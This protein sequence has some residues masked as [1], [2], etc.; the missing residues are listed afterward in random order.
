MAALLA[1]PG[2]SVVIDRNSSSKKKRG[3]LNTASPSA[4]SLFSLSSS[5][6]SPSPSSRRQQRNDDSFTAAAAGVDPVESMISLMSSSSRAGPLSLPPH[7]NE[8]DNDTRSLSLEQLVAF[9]RAKCVD[10]EDQQLELVE[11]ISMLDPNFVELASARRSLERKSSECTQLQQY[12]S[13]L[14][15]AILNEKEKS[16]TMAGEIEKL[17]IA[18]MEAKRESEKS[19]EQYGG[20]TVREDVTFYRDCRPKKLETTS[21]TTKKAQQRQKDFSRSAHVFGSQQQQQQSEEEE[22]ESSPPATPTRRQQLQQQQQSVSR[23]M[24]PA[25]SL[26]GS[27]VKNNNNS[28][29]TTSGTNNGGNINNSFS[30]SSAQK[31]QKK[32]ETPIHRAHSANN[33]SRQV[34]RTVYLPNERADALCL[35][36]ESL[37]SQLDQ[38]KAMAAERQQIMQDEK[39]KIE[40]IY[41]NQIHENSDQIRQLGDRCEDVESKWK[42]QVKNFNELL[43]KLA[44]VEREA[45]ETQVSH[46][47]VLD[48]LQR[49]KDEVHEELVGLKHKVMNHSEAN[50]RN[51]TSRIIARDAD[52]KKVRDEYRSLQGMY[53]AKLKDLQAK[54]SSR[55]DAYKSLDERR[56][57]EISAFKKD[58]VFFRGAL[59]EFEGRVRNRVRGAEKAAIKHHKPSVTSGLLRSSVVEKLARKS[60]G[61]DE[62][63]RVVGGAESPPSSSNE[64]ANEKFYGG[65]GSTGTLHFDVQNLK[66][67]IFSLQQKYVAN[68]E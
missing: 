28:S 36:V 27:L 22:D 4:S 17:Q 18:V 34:L 5:P 35:L 8:N 15:N 30:A 58:I 11:T 29:N 9:Y 21:T 37:S 2:I 19:E 41:L 55:N 24:S 64:N 51:L 42:N 59:E 23:L 60:G 26:R 52:V 12:A 46:V 38:H 68:V 43:H 61:R 25:R 3:N 32:R 31:Q 53:D 63:V 56:K 10:Y 1:S 39:Q 44:V 6:S 47:E 67:R 54:L 20:V 65:R 49:E 40:D 14:N 57:I 13:S 7:S 50:H 16:L 33:T 62:V 48:D 66:S 45:A